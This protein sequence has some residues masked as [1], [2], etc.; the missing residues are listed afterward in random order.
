MTKVST[1]ARK[2][3]LKIKM[4]E[5]WGDDN[6]VWKLPVDEVRAASKEEVDYMVGRKIWDVRPIEECWRVTGKAPVSTRWADTDK[7][8]MTG[9]MLIGSRL[10][11]REFNGGIRSG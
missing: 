6:E 2:E 8:L 9:Q 11:A 1:Q 3:A 7:G 5:A 4:E 10:V